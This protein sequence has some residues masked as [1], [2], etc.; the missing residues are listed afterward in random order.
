MTKRLRTFILSVFFMTALGGCSQ[1]PEEEPIV[2]T[3]YNGPVDSLGMPL[4]ITVSDLP[5]VPV[6]IRGPFEERKEPSEGPNPND[7][8]E[9]G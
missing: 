7:E 6:R 3:G 8:A 2:D 9:P 5:E 1:P 4:E